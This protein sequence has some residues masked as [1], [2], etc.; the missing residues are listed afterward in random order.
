[1]PTPEGRAARATGSIEPGRPRPRARRR[2]GAEG[3]AGR[4]SRGS[5]RHAAAWRRAGESRRSRGNRKDPYLCPLSSIVIRFQY[6][7]TAILAGRERGR[8]GGVL[9]DRV[10]LRVRLVG[11]LHLGNATLLDPGRASARPG[12]SRPQ[13]EDTTGRPR[14]GVML[15][16]P[17]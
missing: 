9:L 1:A 3:G 4:G 16:A 7:P 6:S 14:A 8:K 12:F 2:R 10:A 17:A 11:V 13:L 15:R 5:R